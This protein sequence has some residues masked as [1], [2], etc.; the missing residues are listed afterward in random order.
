MPPGH[1]Y[2][3]HGHFLNL[4]GLGCMPG[5]YFRGRTLRTLYRRGCR[6]VLPP[7]SQLGFHRI[8]C[9]FTVTYPR[10]CK[11]LRA[12][13]QRLALRGM[14]A[15]IRSGEG[16]AIGHEFPHSFIRNADSLCSPTAPPPAL[17]AGSSTNRAGLAFRAELSTSGTE[18]LELTRT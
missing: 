10:K 6:I 18:R 7:R 8:H 13:F 15:T 17:V 14:H 1:S 16:L 2:G 12:A 4:D 9:R 5:S 11:R 3:P